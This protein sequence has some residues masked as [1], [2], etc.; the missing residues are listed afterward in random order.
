MYL[1]SLISHQEIMR[2][3]KDLDQMMKVAS[4]TIG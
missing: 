4:K 2:R 3:L 1:Q